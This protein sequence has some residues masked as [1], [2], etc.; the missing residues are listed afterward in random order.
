MNVPHIASSTGQG[1]SL[2][3]GQLE[4][5]QSPFDA[6]YPVFQARPT[7]RVYVSGPWVSAEAVFTP[8]ASQV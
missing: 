6:Q 8:N 7:T 4:G 5:R 2:M 1:I 3:V